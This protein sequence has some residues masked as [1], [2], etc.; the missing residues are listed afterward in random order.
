[1]QGLMEKGWECSVWEQSTDAAVGA[2]KGDWL[3]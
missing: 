1:M 3:F 2:G